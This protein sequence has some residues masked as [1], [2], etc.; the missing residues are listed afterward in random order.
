MIKFF[1]FFLVIALAISVA[2]VPSVSFA[3]EE[4]TTKAN[5]ANEREEFCAAAKVT[6]KDKGV[7]AEDREEAKKIYKDCKKE[8]R[9]KKRAQCIP[10]GSRLNRC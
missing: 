6:S 2:G 8:A 10:S 1:K 7:S 9:K 5:K 4:E 3:Q